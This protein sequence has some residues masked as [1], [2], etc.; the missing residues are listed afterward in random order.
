MS[1]YLCRHFFWTF[2]KLFFACYVW[3]YNELK[4]FNLV[5]ETGQWSCGVG[6]CP[7]SLKNG[8]PPGRAHCG[9]CLDCTRSGK[10]WKMAPERIWQY[11]REF[12]K[13]TKIG[14]WIYFQKSYKFVLKSLKQ[15]RLTLDSTG[16]TFDNKV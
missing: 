7:F 14:I 1:C 2:I 12:L 6:R 13:S 11:C 9:Q 3:K 8:Q 16:L 10:F 4:C 15:L 5:V